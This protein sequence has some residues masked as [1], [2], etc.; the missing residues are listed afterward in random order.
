MNLIIFT[1]IKQIQTMAY[2]ESAD[3]LKAM[4]EKAIADHKITQAEM[5]NILAIATE[6]M[7]IDPQEQA[8]LTQ[9]REL[10]ENGS[11][12]LIP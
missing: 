12:E 3:R 11:V 5:D 6:D 8:L 1:S 10:I 2:S 7:H 9:L 4:I